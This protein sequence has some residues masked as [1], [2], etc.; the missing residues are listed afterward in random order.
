MHPAEMCAV[1]RRTLPYFGTR[2]AS[3]RK[4]LVLRIL[5]YLSHLLT[6]HLSDKSFIRWLTLS[7]LYPP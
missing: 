3:L 2:R 5:Q 7:I 4:V 6:R 1:E